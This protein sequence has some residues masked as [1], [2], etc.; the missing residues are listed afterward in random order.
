[1]DKLLLPTLV[2]DDSGFEMALAI[3][4]LTADGRATFAVP[5]PVG[6]GL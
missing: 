4:S 3:K 5:G 1:M 6:P 2:T